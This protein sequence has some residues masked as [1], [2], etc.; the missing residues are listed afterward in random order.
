MVHGTFATCDM[1]KVAHDLFRSVD[2]G[3]IQFHMK[4]G[5]INRTVVSSQ[6]LVDGVCSGTFGHETMPALRDMVDLANMRFDDFEDLGQPFECGI[7]L[8]DL[9][10]KFAPLADAL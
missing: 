4:L 10:L 7:G 3:F 5:C 6:A 9:H 8:F 2:R 1:Q